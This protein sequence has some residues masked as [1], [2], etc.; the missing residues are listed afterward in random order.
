V[1]HREELL[2]EALRLQEGWAD[3]AKG[4]QILSFEVIKSLR[5]THK[6]PDSRG[7]RKLLKTRWGGRSSHFR[8][9]ERFQV[10]IHTSLCPGVALVLDFAPERNAS[11]LSLFPTLKD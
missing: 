10:P 2:N 9:L 1:E 3:L 5:V 6:E 8:L 7:G 4:G 11:S